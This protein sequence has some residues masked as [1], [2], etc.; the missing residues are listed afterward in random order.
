MKDIVDWAQSKFGFYVDRSYS[1]GRWVLTPGPIKLAEY[2]Q[3]ILRHIFT[4]DEVGRWPYDTVAWCEP[5]KSGKSAIAG[6]VAEYVA[7]HGDGNSSIVMASNKQDQAASLMF[8]SLT[9]SIG[10]NPHLP[11]VAPGRLSVTFRNGTEVKAIASNSKG[12]A[13]ARFSLALFDELWAYV[14]QDSERLWAE[15]KTDPTRLNSLKFAIGYAGYVGESVLWEEQLNIGLKGQPVKDLLD[16]D[17]GHE[18]PACWANGRHFTFWSHIPRQPWQTDGWLASQQ[19]SLRPAEYAR[20]IECYFA[21]GT[22]NFCEPEA[23]AALISPDHHPLP[24]GDPRPVYVGLDVATSAGGDD[25]ALVGLYPDEGRVKVAFHM[26]WSGKDRKARLKLK[27]TVFPYL[28]RARAD[29]NLQG[30][31]FDPYQALSLAEDLRAAGIRCV[32]VPQTHSSRGPRDTGLLDMVNARQLVLYEHKDFTALGS[33]ASAKELGNGLI[34]LKKASGRSKIDLLIA[35]SNT[36]SEALYKR[37]A[38]ATFSPVNP[39]Y[40][41]GIWPTG[42]SNYDW[43]EEEQRIIAERKAEAEAA[44]PLFLKKYF[45][46]QYQEYLAR[47]QAEQ[48]AAGQGK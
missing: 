10:L 48:S 15:F 37:P 7:L 24:A 43:I 21:E 41:N 38:V 18:G 39:F 45:P 25:C 16:I 36:A 20:M 6:L 13:G 33:K 23:W 40:D 17:N 11:K 12:E 46:V 28:V 8:K 31:W 26:V 3:R 47:L 30:V 19:A 42:G 32:E 4:P 9:D 27:E 1:R 29:Y 34:F 14:Y 2:H 22:G 5:A 44:Q 35:L